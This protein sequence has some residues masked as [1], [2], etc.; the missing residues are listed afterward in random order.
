MNVWGFMRLL[1][2]PTYY[3]QSKQ[4]QEIAENKYDLIVSAN[5]FVLINTFVITNNEQ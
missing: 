1:C 4:D 5:V 3:I 2:R